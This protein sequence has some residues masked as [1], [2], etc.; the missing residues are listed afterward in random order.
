MDVGVVVGVG[1]AEGRRVGVGVRLAGV[2]VGVADAVGVGVGVR[3]AGVSVGAA[4]WVG[5]GV[6]VGLA[7]MSVGAR[8]G[9]GVGVMV[10]VMVGVAVAVTATVAVS[11]T[12]V[13]LIA[14]RPGGD[15]LKPRVTAPSRPGV[16]VPASASW[17]RSR[18]QQIPSKARKL[19]IAQTGALSRRVGFASPI[20][21]DKGIDRRRSPFFSILFLVA[22]LAHAAVVDAQQGAVR[23]ARFAG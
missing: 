4:D 7:G 6:G 20:R 15:A 11:R 9:E 13:V 5:V 16:S 21:R 23:G 14:V 17:A 8:D 22:D 19:A 18:R 2:S 12:L 10:G 1:L 3:L